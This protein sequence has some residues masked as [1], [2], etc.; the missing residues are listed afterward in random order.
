MFIMLLA[1]ALLFGG[2]VGF[3]D[4]KA[5]M[6]KKFRGHQNLPAQT[7]STIVAKM[8]T[9]Q[10]RLSA[11]G[12]LRAVRGVDISS[13][14]AGMV[15]EVEMQ[16]GAHVASGD[17]LFQLRDAD[18][19]AK[20]QQLKAALHLA[21][22]S[23]ERAR[24]QLAA[25][26][27]SQ[28]DYDTAK[29]DLEEATANVDMQSALL[30]KKTI[31]APFAGTLG[32]TT[33]NPGQYINAGETLVTLQKL[34]P[35]YLDFDLPQ[36]SLSVARTGQKVTATLDAYPGRNFEGDITAIDPK[37]DA[38]TRNVRI[39]ARMNNSDHSL[40]PGMYARV[41]VAAGSTQRYLTL[42]QTAVT[43]NPYGSTVYLVKKTAA[44]PGAKAGLEARQAFVTTGPTRGDQVAILKGI[45]QGDIVVTSG[46][47]KLKS[48][49]PLVIDN[50]VRPAN[51]PN[52]TPQEQ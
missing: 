10:P 38:D 9:W 1:V 20:L 26:T 47:L 25:H 13:E 34:D 40:V 23:F 22:L 15:T 31:R 39:E 14:V 19:M 33:V 30:V 12:T 6:I 24:K 51:S 17:V 7:V 3:N 52:P 37:V 32:I 21:E 5:A 2:I 48:G 27:I 4:Y 50:S 29:A 11:I 44:Q 35:I 45:K 36:Q 18:D 46:Q 41:Q 42:P 28:S 8:E 49:T 16:S 43:F